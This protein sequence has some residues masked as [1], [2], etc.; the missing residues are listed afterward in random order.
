M[1][2]GIRAVAGVIF[3]A[4]LIWFCFWATAKPEPDP[5]ANVVDRIAAPAA[6]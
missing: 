5:N 4:W 1:E 2:N 6:R 3:A